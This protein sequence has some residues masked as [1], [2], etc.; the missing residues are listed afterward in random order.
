[1]KTL[2]AQN[3]SNSIYQLT[4]DC[5]GSAGPEVVGGEQDHLLHH[6]N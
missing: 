3:K 1:M 4:G 6:G 5:G 2:F